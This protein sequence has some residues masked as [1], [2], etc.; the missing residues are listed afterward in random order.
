[1]IDITPYSFLWVNV[2]V[3]IYLLI[4]AFAVEKTGNKIPLWLTVIFTVVM[5]IRLFLPVEFLKISSTIISYSV[6]PPIDGIINK[7]VVSL[8]GETGINIFGA[9][10]ILWLAG[11]FA[12]LIKYFY[13]YYKLS[14]IVNTLPE[15]DNNYAYILNEIK[16]EC[17]FRFSTK[18]IVNS[19][20]EMPGEYGLFKQTIFIN[21]YDYTDDEIRYILL[22]ELVHFKYRTN[23]LSIYLNVLNM[24]FWWNPVIYIY[25][26][27]INDSIEIYVDSKVTENMDNRKRCDY[28]KCIFKVSEIISND[29]AAD[30]K[31]VTPFIKGDRG[32]FLLKRFNIIRYRNKIN[33][34]LC[35]GVAVLFSI[36][37]FIS[38]KY[39]VQPGWEPSNE[40][41]EY[42]KSSD[43]NEDNSYITIED[44]K[45]ILYYNGERFAEILDTSQ[46]PGVPII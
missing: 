31:Y 39:V 23:W 45:Y 38:C 22:H 25:K 35:V 42:M 46:F 8:S 3:S 10:V 20:V 21:D 27:C 37:L 14:R 33:L 1:M 2:S 15:K 28:I 18:L 29:D 16:E 17:N 44:G 5:S 36:C 26:K 34:M 32:Q 24:I 6:L 19:A 30:V 7:E 9:V 11:S 13:N 41:T 43:F 40:D 4:Y 12:V